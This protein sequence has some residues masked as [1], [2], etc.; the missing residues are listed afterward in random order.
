MSRRPQVLRRFTSL[1]TLFAAMTFTL[2]ATAAD[3]I[4]TAALNHPGRTAEDKTRDTGESPGELL[5]LGGIKPGMNVLDY[6][7][8]GGY[9]SEIISYI[10]GPTGHVVLLNNKPWDGWV[11]KDLKQR[12]ANHRLKN[13]EHKTVNL[14]HMGLGQNVYD[15]VVMVKVYHDLYAIDPSGEW[16]KID[17]KG[18][19]DQ[20]VAALKPG[21]TLLLV[22]HSAK[23]GTG[24]K[25]ATDLHRIDEAFAKQEF[26]SRGLKLVAQSD[27]LRK[28]EDKRELNTYKGPGLG[29]TDRFVLVF[30]KT[31]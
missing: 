31:A 22:D 1:A 21:G 16:P 5:R 4:Y 18:S 14:D 26:E 13:V 11:E 25:D 9:Y 3:D 8:G 6:L 15:A 19:L 23:P 24:S 10:V 29:H 27:L 2:A 7:G 20:V 28:P 30:R 17:I 12:L